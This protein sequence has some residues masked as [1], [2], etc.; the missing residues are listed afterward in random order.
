MFRYEYI[1]IVTYSHD[2]TKKHY[3][4]QDDDLPVHKYLPTFTM[5]HDVSVAYKLQ[6][7]KSLL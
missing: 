1:P 6:E 7:S 3:L 4:T 5:L 2:T